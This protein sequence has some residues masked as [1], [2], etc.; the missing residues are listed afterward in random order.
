LQV[1][2]AFW[3][4][5]ELGLLGSYAFVNDLKARNQL[6]NIAAY[7]N[8]DMAASPNYIVQVR[9]ARS[10]YPPVFFRG[11]GRWCASVIVSAGES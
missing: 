3:G 4:A 8:F 5:E 7:L 11:V 10:Q 1:T 6:D 9:R 2:F